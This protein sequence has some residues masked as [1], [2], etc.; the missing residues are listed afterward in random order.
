M[1]LTLIVSLYTSRVVLEVLGVVDFGI[2][3]VVG[4]VVAMLTFLTNTMASASQRFFAY[5]IGKGDNKK[6]NQTFNLTVLIYIF[7]V[8][9]ILVL[10]ETVGLYFVKDKLNV[11]LNRREIS[12][13]VY[14]FAVLSFIFTILRIPLN[15]MIIA[16]EKMSF[17]AWIS[18]L[19]VLL[20]LAVVY[21]LLHFNTDKLLLYSVLNF[22]IILIITL[23]YQIYVSKNFAYC[24]YFFYWNADEFKRIFYFAGWN[25]F[26]SVANVAKNQGVNILLNIFF[27]P[28]VNAA[29]AIAFQINSQVTTFVGNVQIATAPQMTKYYASNEI[30]ELKKLF[31]NSSKLT[32]F[33]FFFIGFPF[34]ILTPTILNLWLVDVPEY[35]IDFTRLI[36]INTLVDCLGGTSNLVIHATGSVKVYKAVSGFIMFLNLP[37][38]FLLI[39]LG[40]SP[41]VTFIVSIIIS[42]I[43]VIARLLIIEQQVK[44]GFLDYFKSVLCYDFLVFAA[45]II[46]P[47]LLYRY[48][49]DS[50]LSLILM[51]VICSFSVLVSIYFFGLSASERKSSLSFLKSKLKK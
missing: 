46:M 49:D 5:D 16:Y 38:S 9:I 28:V 24:R 30:V 19:E 27:N 33:L 43:I 1:F 50:L 10:S 12:L 26:D 11:P 32:F 2:Y 44:I 37:I 45:S 23:F 4:G 7:F 14:Q 48:F 29:R 13:W 18:I 3:S 25:M 42:L 20:K 41:A 17:Y 15:A 8:L 36:V 31:F 34:Y 22:V 47:L 51:C 40:Y 6:L 35:T 39:K 21:L